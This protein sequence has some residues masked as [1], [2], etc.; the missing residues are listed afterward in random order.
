MWVYDLSGNTQMRRLTQEG[1]N[2]SP[3]WTPDGERITFASDR[4]GSW[5]IYSQPA[6]GTD[7]AEPLTAESGPDTR[8]W[9]DSWSP[10]GQTLSFSQSSSGDDGVWTLE[11]DNASEPELF[12]D[13][14]DGSDQFGSS[15]S[16][17]GNWIAFHSDLAGETGGQVHVLPFPA[18]GVEPRQVTQD[19]GMFPL[20]ARAGDE[21][22]YRRPVAVGGSRLVDAL[23]GVDVRTDAALEWGAEQR[24]PI[25]EF[26]ATGDFR[27]YDIMPDGRRFLV[28]KPTEATDTE[29]SAQAA[30]IHVVL[31]WRQELLDRV[32]MD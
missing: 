27:D 1:N 23:L 5:R 14:T 24:L 12:Y 2:V 9:P 4:D 21:L 11:L 10:D 28:I 17:D 32:P 20:W 15:F 3:I 25:E 29:A 13:I 6:N 8:I 16:P 7:V 30:Q 18:T 22:F 19:G 31:D 26:W